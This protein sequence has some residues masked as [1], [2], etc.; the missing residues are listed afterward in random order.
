MISLLITKTLV[1]VLTSVYA[2]Q[3]NYFEEL[4]LKSQKTKNSDAE[5]DG[6]SQGTY[7]AVVAECQAIALSQHS[8]SK[9]RELS[10]AAKPFQ[11]FTDMLQIQT[12]LCWVTSTT[13]QSI[14][15]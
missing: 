13:P 3:S 7:V 8:S 11:N 5:P 6:A 10:C 4:D 1:P 9:G 2:K 15:A 14:F 12:N